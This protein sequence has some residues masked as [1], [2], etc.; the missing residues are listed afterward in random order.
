MT[1]EEL[2]TLIESYCKRLT[3][4]ND[5]FELCEF[6]L[7]YKV[8]LVKAFIRHS[9]VDYK[10]QYKNCTDRKAKKG[11]KDLYYYEPVELMETRAKIKARRGQ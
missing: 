11:F 6:N 8:A 2:Q 4:I 3:F 9:N 1:K 7:K 10:T 5:C